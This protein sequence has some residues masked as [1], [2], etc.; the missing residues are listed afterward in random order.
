MKR[1]ILKLAAII[2][3]LLCVTTAVLWLIGDVTGLSIR[4]IR[5]DYSRVFQTRYAASVSG[6]GFAFET[7]VESPDPPILGW[8]FGHD[9]NDYPDPDHTWRI[10]D[11][12]R[13][14]G[15]VF[16]CWSVLLLSSLLPVWWAIRARTK[17][18]MN[19]STCST[20]G[21]DLTGNVS[22]VC[23]ECGTAIPAKS[24]APA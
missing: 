7:Y 15:V 10:I 1:R 6:G 11:R 23:P 21:Y 14:S 13:R 17:P 24:E 12:G 20:C 18:A 5:M 22:G 8:Y 2:S 3:L 16:P 9:F 4:G 19:R